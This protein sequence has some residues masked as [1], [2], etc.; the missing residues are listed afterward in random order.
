MGSLGAVAV[1]WKVGA[2]G[3][4][5]GWEVEERPGSGRLRQ[6]LFSWWRLW[7][8]PRQLRDPALPGRFDQLVQGAA[9]F[10]FWLGARFGEPRETIFL[11]RFPRLA[12][13]V[14]WE[15]LLAKKQAVTGSAY[16]A[17]FVRQPDFEAGSAATAIDRPLRSLILLGDDG[18]RLGTRWRL[19]LHQEVRILDDTWNRL[20]TSVQRRIERPIVE[21]PASSQLIQLIAKARPDVLWFSGHGRAGLSPGLLFRDG[22]IAAKAFAKSVA[23]SGRPPL[24]AVFWACDTGAP[25]DAKRD[26]L[27]ARYP[28][29]CRELL[30]VGTSAVLAMQAPIR[31]ASALLMARELFD[32]LAAG[33]PLVQASAR[34]RT[35]LLGAGLRLAHPL[36]WASPVVWSASPPAERLQW[37]LAPQPLVQ[38]QVLGRQVLQRLHPGAAVADHGFTEL[39]RQRAEAWAAGDGSK[40][41]VAG[42]G[43]ESEHLYYW[44]RALQAIQWRTERFVLA[45]D[46]ELESPND[47]LG[48]ALQEWA[49]S[50]LRWRQPEDL[51][52]EV[53][54]VLQ[55]L[56][57]QPTSGWRDL[58]RLKRLFLAVCFRRGSSGFP[59][60][61][62]FWQPLLDPEGPP[63]A[64]LSEQHVEPA[65]QGVW[66]LDKLEEV[67]DVA[68]RDRFEEIV[69]RAPRLARALAVLDSPQHTSDLQVA[70]GPGA[71]SL[72]AWQGGESLLVATPS[73]LVLSATARR[74]MRD[75]MDPECLRD[76][77][78]DCARIL[79]H[80][81]LAASESRQEELLEHLVAGGRVPD[82]LQVAAGLCR[83]HAER[84]NPFG[85]VR[86]LRRLGRDQRKLPMNARL[87]AAWAF[88]RLGRDPAAEIWLR[89]SAP[90]TA[91][92][93]ARYHALCAEIYKNRGDRDGALREIDAAI[94]AA[95]RAAAEPQAFLVGA[96]RRLRALRQD[97]ARILQYLFGRLQEAAAEYERLIAE[98]NGEPDAELDQA[99]ALRNQAEC[100]DDLAASADGGRRQRAR[101][102]LADAQRLA[103]RHP[104]SPIHAEVL[105][106]QAK[107][108]EHDRN[109]SKAL[110]DL[111][112]CHDAALEAR[113]YMLAAIVENRRFW[114]G[115]EDPASAP[116]RWRPIAE[117][118]EGFPYHGW[119]VRTLLTG[120][121][122]AAR[123]LMTLGRGTEALSLLAA[124]ERDFRRHPSFTMGSDRFRIAATFA[125][126]ERLA[127]AGGEDE[128]PWSRF[129]RQNAW[130]AE[131]LAA[132]ERSFS[133]PE[134]VWAEVD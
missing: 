84:G 19:D 25:G 85:V 95:Q 23:D 24:Y 124:N 57:H 3:R 5:Q 75:G 64:V 20:D 74:L 16:Q 40:M 66:I 87:S 35:N 89:D 68:W 65:P 118:L 133:G 61:D 127:L 14:P 107:F 10:E 30:K 67:D 86:T 39:E 82:A 22:W 27:G 104:Q 37:N 91:G 111:E 63:V 36:D 38:L 88:L 58:C 109:T 18:A 43:A 52:Q 126:M 26:D 62:W 112:R 32:H 59:A 44:A 50:L 99:A 13:T 123:R 55:G 71:R 94:A 33:M 28:I 9:G 96:D 42:S 77:H 81:T 1:D 7:R 8:L 92:D 41:W 98:W 101:D 31:D 134:A 110:V 90:A 131:W 125:G 97:R 132:P 60:P 130:A 106:Q 47:D 115:E 12:W 79:I 113:Y 48:K 17:S 11:L 100:L 46:L 121:L 76:A 122:R 21:R 56:E 54:R 72:E 83:H 129:L 6:Y 51:P 119:A 116:D 103:D 102:L 80:S 53:D 70:D 15:L 73:G 128:R 2:G 108:A 117:V 45:V 120:R 49:A 78:L 114:L 93:Q 34:A 4:R 105:Y 69:G 29:L